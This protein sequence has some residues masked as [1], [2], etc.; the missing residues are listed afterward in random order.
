MKPERDSCLVEVL[1]RL[2]N[3]GVI[4]N[5]DLIISVGG[6]P[7][8]GLNLRAALASMET[9]LH[10]GIMQDWDESNRERPGLAGSCPKIEDGEEI[11]LKSFGYIRQDCG[12]ANNWIPGSWHLTSRRLF[13]WRSSPRETVIDIPLHRI[14]LLKIVEAPQRERSELDLVYSSGLARIYVSDLDEFRS[15]LQKALLSL[16]ALES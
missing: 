6:V 7:L 8:I 3:K 1:D 14:H 4:L 2:L 11:I 16:K 5:A 9:M 10:Y 15:A 13:L 12:T